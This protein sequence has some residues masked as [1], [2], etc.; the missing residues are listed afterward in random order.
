MELSARR[1]VFD[2][3]ID[4]ITATGTQRNPAVFS[5]ASGAQTTMADRVEWNTKTWHVKFKNA[6]TRVR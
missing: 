4:L 2:P 5:E 3:D 1:L 6:S